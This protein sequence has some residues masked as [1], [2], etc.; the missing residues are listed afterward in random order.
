MNNI[1]KL[2]LS[3]FFAIISLAG[4]T[5][6]ELFVATEPASN[7]PKNSIRLRLS[8][9]G[10]AETDL[11]SRTS[12]GVMYGLSKEVMLSA[13]AY[14]SNFYQ[15]KQQINGYSF[16]AKYRFLNIDN[17]QKHFRGALFAQYSTVK[18]PIIQ[19][20]INLAGENNGLQGGLVFT[21]LIHKLAL[22]G[23]ILYTKS[24]DK[25]APGHEAMHGNVQNSIAYTIS[26][27]YLLFPK[28]Y[29]DY[30]QVNTNVYMEFLGDSHTRSGKNFFDAAPAVQ[31]IFNS[32]LRLD[33][34]KRFQLWGDMQRRFKNLY[35][36]RVEYYLF[37]VI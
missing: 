36:V 8:N 22:S 10:V 19:D 24:L 37:N 23:S 29:K 2:F 30:K 18:F 12:F 32:K 4:A 28:E 26:S 3:F 6:Q 1:F 15:Q 31:F 14:M 9:E 25:F 7:I 11:K 33:L 16:Y 27:G 13:N 20:E 17:V 35:Q 5:A 21:Q 34:S